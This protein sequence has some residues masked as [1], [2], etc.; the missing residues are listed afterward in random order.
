MESVSETGKEADRRKRS[1]G[2]SMKCQD[3]SF[4]DLIHQPSTVLLRLS[5]SLP[6]LCT[7]TIC[8]LRKEIVSE[9]GF[10]ARD[11]NA[12]HR[13]LEF[14]PFFF[15]SF[16][17]FVFMTCILLQIHH[18]YCAGRVLGEGLIFRGTRKRMICWKQRRSRKRERERERSEIRR[19][20][21]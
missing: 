20:R 15:F 2:W 19:L 11:C 10:D 7:F 4:P 12:I 1:K 13:Q 14:F 8:L 17:P 18:L 16:Y 6:C 5:H 3:R 9:R 21:R